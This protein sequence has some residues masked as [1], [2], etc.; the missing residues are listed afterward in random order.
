[1]PT[2]DPGN[3]NVGA[4]PGGGSGLKSYSALQLFFLMRL[5][6]LVRRR[7]EEMA[8]LDPSHWKYKL[9]NKALYSTYCDCVQEGVGEEAKVLLGQQQSGEKN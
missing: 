5:S 1:M 2:A 7:K 8:S 4:A 9:L 3:P 6:Y